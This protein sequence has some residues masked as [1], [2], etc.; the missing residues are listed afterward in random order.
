MAEPSPTATT[1]DSNNKSYNVKPLIFDG[2]KFE[3]W[4]DRLES[5]FL[6]H[7][8]DLWDLVVDGYVSPKDSTGK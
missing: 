7:D 2:E 6:C 8:I 3:Y 1:S 5:F 4:K